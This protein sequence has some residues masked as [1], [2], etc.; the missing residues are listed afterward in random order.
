MQLKK[1]LV[2]IARIHTGDFRLTGNQN[3]IIANISSSN[4]QKINSILKKHGI[5]HDE[6]LSGMRL[7]SLACVALNTCPLAFAEAE[8]Y[9]PSLITKL[10]ESL[11]GKRP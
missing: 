8:R 2:E 1:A 3:L 9:L 6:K 10:E 4:K 5:I 7:N 11:E